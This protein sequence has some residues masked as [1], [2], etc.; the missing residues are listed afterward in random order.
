MWSRYPAQQTKLA[1]GTRFEQHNAYLLTLWDDD[2]PAHIEQQRHRWL[3]PLESQADAGSLPTN[4]TAGPRPLA[5]PGETADSAGPKQQI[6]DT[7]REV[8]DDQLYG[9][10]A[11]IIDLGYVYDVRFRAGVAH[12]VVTMPHL[13]RPMHEFLVTQGGGR[14]D[15]GIRERVLRIAGVDAVVVTPTWNPPWS[16]ARL[17]AAGRRAVGLD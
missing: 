11:N 12:I 1:A 4:V 8:L 17:T 6:Y 7:L 14:V 13:G 2:A 10:D 15:E 5:R 9:A 16:L 3:N